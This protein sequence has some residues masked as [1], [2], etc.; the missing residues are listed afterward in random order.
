MKSVRLLAFALMLALGIFALST[1]A[2][3]STK[4]K[5]KDVPSEACEPGAIASS[6]NVLGRNELFGIDAISANDAWAVGNYYS[7]TNGSLLTLIEHFDGTRWTVVPSPSEPDISNT[8]TAVAAVSASDVWA[9]GYLGTTTPM[10]PL[11]LHWD[12]TVWSII[13]TPTLPPQ[14]VSPGL[15]GVAAISTDDVWAVGFDSRR[16]AL[17]M[18]WDGTEWSLV[19]IPTDPASSLL[20]VTAVSTDDVWAVG[21]STTGFSGTYLILHWDGSTWSEVSVSGSGLLTAVDAVSADDVW[22]VGSTS[23]N[24]TLTMHWDGAAWSVVSSPN[25]SGLGNLLQGVSAVSADDVW[26]VGFSTPNILGDYSNFM[27]LIEHWNGTEWSIVDNPAATSGKLY[28]VDALSTSNAFAAGAQFNPTTLIERWD[29][30]QWNVTP[31]QNPG[32]ADNTLLSVDALSPTDVWAVGYYDTYGPA[33]VRQ[34]T[35]IQHWDGYNWN[36]VPSPNGPINENILNSVDAISANDV[37]AVGMTGVG[38]DFRA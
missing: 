4:D 30:T 20:A 18:H 34:S 27:P 28:A 17:T 5:N 14:V 19:S 12:G 24:Q 32:L 11:A 10:G 25:I 29:G 8:L 15:N 26:A 37:W 22:A 6:P 2:Q 3:A 38:G 13:P 33:A 9:V 35:L 7:P 36:I 21:G 16:H 1:P 31:S 23:T